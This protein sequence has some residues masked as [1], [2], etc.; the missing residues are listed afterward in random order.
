LLRLCRITYSSL[1]FTTTGYEP[2]PTSKPSKYFFYQHTWHDRSPTNHLNH[3]TNNKSKNK[4]DTTTNVTPNATKTSKRTTG[5][6][7]QSE[8]ININQ[9][10]YIRNPENIPYNEGDSLDRQINISDRNKE[11]CDE[12]GDIVNS[13]EDGVMKPSDEDPQGNVLAEQEQAIIKMNDSH[14]TPTKEETKTAAQLE[15][16]D[17]SPSPE[18]DRR[19]LN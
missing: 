13:S 16:K 8:K 1:S 17:S 3:H 5:T 12:A 19:R 4:T 6:E 2:T 7:E 9:K 14:R 15:N 11:K 18:P 10:E